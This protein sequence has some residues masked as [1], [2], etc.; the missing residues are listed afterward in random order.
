MTNPGVGLKS[1]SMKLRSS[2]NINPSPGDY[3]VAK[4][5]LIKKTYKKK[6]PMCYFQGSVNKPGYDIKQ[7]EEVKGRL[8][9]NEPLKQVF[10]REKHYP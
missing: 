7:K 3:S 9:N 10:K 5:I 2:Y 6:G 8:V 1:G 4:D